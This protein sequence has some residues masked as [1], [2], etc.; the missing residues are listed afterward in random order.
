MSRP[1]LRT[2]FLSAALAALVVI[3]TPPAAARQTAKDQKLAAAS[4]AQTSTGSVSLRVMLVIPDAVRNYRLSV[5]LSHFD[6]GRR[7]A[8][9]AEK[10]FHQT[11]ATVNVVPAIPD[12]PHALDQTD[13]VV[14][15]AV[16]EGQ[17]Q[18]GF[19]S[20]TLTL[21]EGFVV[22]DARKVEILRA[23]ETDSGKGRDVNQG[24]DELSGSVVRK[25]LQELFLNAR[26]HDLLSPT[27]AA[28]AEAKPVLADTAV[29]DSAGLDVPPPPPWATSPVPAGTPHNPA[30]K[31]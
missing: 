18:S 6:V 4:G 31:P 7:L 21:T 8:V 3:I 5:F 17:L 15:L 10:I 27:P 1:L 13:L 28:P 23:R 11:F 30:G 14:T 26:V 19:F 20:G 22:A 9:Q 16:P 24:M 12:D 29:M 25:F 2:L